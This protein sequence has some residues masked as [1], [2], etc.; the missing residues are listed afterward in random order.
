MMKLFFKRLFIIFKRLLSFVIVMIMYCI[1]LPYSG[2]LV[3]IGL[4]FYMIKDDFVTQN[5]LYSFT[6]YFNTKCY[7]LDILLKID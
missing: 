6:D 1:C 4:F 2:S 5:K 7:H 3:F